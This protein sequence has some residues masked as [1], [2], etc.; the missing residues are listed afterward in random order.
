MQISQCTV[1]V[2]HTPSGRH[3]C[4]L[5]VLT[6]A[7]SLPLF[8]PSVLCS[9]LCVLFCAGE[10]AARGAAGGVRVHGDE[11]AARGRAHAAARPAGTVPACEC[12]L[13]GLPGGLS[14][15]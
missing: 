2:V 12:V 8:A 5:P 4:S 1:L 7:F 10:E 14:L 6:G 3:I 11:G 15:S 13:A 9:S